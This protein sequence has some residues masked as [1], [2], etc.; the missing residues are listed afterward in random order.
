MIDKIIDILN[1]GGVVI[2]PTDTVYGIFAI[3]DNEKAI[4]KIYKIKKRDY[5][6]PLQIFLPDKKAIKKYAIVN[7]HNEKYI[8]NFLPGKYTLIFKIRK[9]FKRKFKF[10]KGDTIG[11][12]VIKYKLLNDILK[13][14]KKPLAATSA[15][16]SGDK[17]PVK[18]RDINKEILNRVDFFIK[19]DDIVSGTASSVIDVKGK[20]IKILR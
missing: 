8:N 4:N 5:K 7:K 20:E 18:F 15:N 13:K 3:S 11:I 16:L 2:L 19:N 9:T 1:K 6:K 12:R 14:I 17:T 10:I